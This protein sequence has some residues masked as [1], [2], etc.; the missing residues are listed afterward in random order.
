MSAL[1]CDQYILLD[2]RDAS[3]RL[4]IFLTNVSVQAVD[5]VLD[6]DIRVGLLGF[7]HNLAALQRVVQTT[8]RHTVFRGGKGVSAVRVDGFIVLCGAIQH[9]HIAHAVV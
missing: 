1:L 3:L 6:E 4:R 2:D 5:D 7:K 8:V 9:L